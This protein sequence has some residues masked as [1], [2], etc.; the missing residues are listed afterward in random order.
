MRAERNINSFA[1]IFFIGIFFSILAIRLWHLQILRGAEYSRMAFENRLRLEKVPAPRGII[2]D[3]WGK[4]LVQSSAAF[5]ITL[6]PEL[7]D[8]T[9]LGRAADFLGL[10]PQWL[11]KRADRARNTLDPIIVREGLNL[12]EVSKVE[13]RLSD[14]PALNVMVDKSRKYLYGE[15]GA[16]LLGYLGRITPEQAELPEFADV[17]MQAFIGQFGVEKLYDKTLRGVPGERAIEVNALGK[18]IRVIAQTPPRK[19]EGLHLSIDIEMMKAVEESFGDRKGAFVAIRPS[20][21]EILGMVSK[22]SYDP[23]LFSFGIKSGD[24]GRLINDPEKPMLNR[25]LQSQYPPG[26]TFKIVTGLAALESGKVTPGRVVVCNGG[27]QYGKWRFG[28]WQKRG[29]GALAFEAGLIQ[30]CDVYFYTVGALTGIDSIAKM[31][32]RL[33]LGAT[34]TL[35]LAMER[36]G[37]I[38]DE[39]WKLKTKGE[40]WYLGETYNAAIGQ[41]YVAV[42]PFQLARMI[43]TVAADG[44]L[45]EPTLKRIAPYEAKR[46]AADSYDLSPENIELVKRALIGVVN[47]PRGTAHAAHSDDFVIAGKTGTAQVYSNANKKRL[48]SATPDALKDHAWFVAYA[49]ASHPEIACA[50][51]VEHG[52]H[53]GSAAAPIAKKAIETYLANLEANSAH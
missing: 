36:P 52:G 2:Y 19:G 33:G 47:D 29:H 17:P 31:A 1:I 53:G 22:P 9:D 27:L 14:F 20:T 49:P 18:Q 43:A 21:G 3:R 28:C 23:N 12:E 13:A 45:Y 32:R 35:G 24:W 6:N 42:T 11:Q 16:H 4:A 44:R 38:P 39:E 5:S 30:S 40:S 7:I 50:V 46:A 51:L 34:S 25:A 37:L 26:S 48:A 41:G 15:V 10:D 8:I